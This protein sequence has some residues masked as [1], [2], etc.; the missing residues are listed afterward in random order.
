MQRELGFE[1]RSRKSHV[2]IKAALVPFDTTKHRLGGE[3][4]DFLSFP[5]FLLVLMLLQTF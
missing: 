4:N 2:K 5:F 3:Y 1:F